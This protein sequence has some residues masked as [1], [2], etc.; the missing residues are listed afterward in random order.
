M[1]KGVITDIFFDLDHTLW[2]FDKNSAL[3]FQKILAESDIKVSL[4]DFLKEYIPLNLSF[5][6]MYRDGKINKEDLRYQRLKTTFD[7]LKYKI[8]DRSIHILSDQYIEHLSGFTHLFPNT[9]DILSYLKPTYKLHII[10]NGFQEIQ[11]KKLNN[12]KIADYFE[13]ITTSEMAGVKKPNPRI[14]EMAL[15]LASIS[16]DTS[17]MIG[18]NLEADILGALNS[19]LHAL[20]FN[21][22]NDP[23]HQYCSTIHHLSEIKRYL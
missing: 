9:V 11:Q 17:L 13:T 20:H 14:F 7:S 15:N 18:D 22:H 5:W 3:T 4:P 21:V 10:T 12:T 1:F 8:T 23:I 6:K 16:P 2:D 19:G